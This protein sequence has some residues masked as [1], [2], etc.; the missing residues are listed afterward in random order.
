MLAFDR[1]SSI[2]LAL[3]QEEFIYCWRRDGMRFGR[4]TMLSAIERFARSQTGNARFEY[5]L[6]IAGVAIAVVTVLASQGSQLPT[7]LARL[8]ADLPV[9]AR[10]L[11]M[12]TRHRLGLIPADSGAVHTSLNYSMREAC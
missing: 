1:I 4:S 3:R 11:T 12:P 9:M 5:G 6:V 2:K 7:E 10:E 8:K